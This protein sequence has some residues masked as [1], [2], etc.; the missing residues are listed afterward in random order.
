[1]GVHM[2]MGREGGDVDH[3]KATKILLNQSSFS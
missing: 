2:S 3:A 1:M